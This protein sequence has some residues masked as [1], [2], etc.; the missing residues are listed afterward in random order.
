M[1]PY[2]KSTTPIKQKYIDNAAQ[3]VVVESLDKDTYAEPVV[4]SKN[5]GSCPT[6]PIKKIDEYPVSEKVFRVLYR[7]RK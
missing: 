1:E 2:S 3:N 6:T 5:W 4:S 7:A